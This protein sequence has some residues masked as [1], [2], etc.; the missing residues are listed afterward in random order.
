MN[1]KRG[2]NEVKEIEEK[3][4]QAQQIVEEDSNARISELHYTKD[5]FLEHMM[6]LTGKLFSNDLFTLFRNFNIPN[7]FWSAPAS[8]T[9]RYHPEIAQGEGGLVRHTLLTMSWV[10]R[11]GRFV[12]AT[13]E[14]LQCAL[15]AAILHDTYK[16]GWSN[17]WTRC[18]TVPEHPIIAAGQVYKLSLDVVDEN[19]RSKYELIRSAIKWHMG[20][21]SPNPEILDYDS[22]FPLELNDMNKVTKMVALADYSSSQK[23]EEMY[24]ILS[25]AYGRE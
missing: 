21:W 17:D 6:N 25:G 22:Y 12:N 16:C 15:M 2:C 9:G 20:I 23:I 7:Q 14:E 10:V 8:M 19:T 24:S 4:A 5:I 1:K 18:G 3:L 13:E 11:W